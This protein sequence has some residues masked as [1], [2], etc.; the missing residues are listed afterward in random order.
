MRQSG[1]CRGF[2]VFCWQCMGQTLWF[3]SPRH[4]QT[5]MQHLMPRCVVVAALQYQRWAGQLHQLRAP[6][7]AA[8]LPLPSSPCRQLWVRVLRSCM[9]PLGPGSTWLWPTARASRSHAACWHTASNQRR[10]PLTPHSTMETAGPSCCRLGPRA[11]C[12]CCCLAPSPSPLCS[13]LQQRASFMAHCQLQVAAV[14][15][16]VCCHVC[17][18]CCTRRTTRSAPCACAHLARN[19]QSC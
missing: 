6:A 8:R 16:S 3:G 17:L 7:A 11:P 19:R 4:P 5:C 18:S 15:R 10:L 14:A 12:T 2:P 13:Q 9:H 1:W